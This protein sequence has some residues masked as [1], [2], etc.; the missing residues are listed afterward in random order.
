MTLRDIQN[1]ENKGTNLSGTE[2]YTPVS[3]TGLP[4]EGIHAVALVLIMILL[5]ITSYLIIDM[6]STLAQDQATYHKIAVKACHSGRWVLN[7]KK[8]CEGL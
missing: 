7:K 4:S 1:T 5:A 8:T 2:N 6:R 3:M